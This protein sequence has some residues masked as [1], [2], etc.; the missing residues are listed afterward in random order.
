MLPQHLYA[1]ED[2]S[3]GVVVGMAEDQR[4]KFAPAQLNI[5][6]TH[7][8]LITEYDEGNAGEGNAGEGHWFG[9]FTL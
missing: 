8:L 7:F 3:L 2:C 4:P 6:S 1:V 5:N 9:L